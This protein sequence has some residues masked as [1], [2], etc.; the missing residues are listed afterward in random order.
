M[1]CQTLFA[2]EVPSLDNLARTG[3]GCL[4]IMASPSNFL[5]IFLNGLKAGMVGDIM[6][7]HAL[8]DLLRLNYQTIS[9]STARKIVTAM[10]KA[11]CTIPSPGRN[12]PVSVLAEWISTP[13]SGTNPADSSTVPNRSPQESGRANKRKGRGTNNRK[14]GSA[15]SEVVQTNGA[16]D[17]PPASNANTPD[18]ATQNLAPEPINQPEP[19]PPLGHTS[20]PKPPSQS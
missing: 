8:Q 20:R 15:A 9:E 5:T 6:I 13:L 2:N 10:R 14:G 12:D 18:P 17:P 19:E 7:H 16:N 4:L 11:G 3:I 1:S